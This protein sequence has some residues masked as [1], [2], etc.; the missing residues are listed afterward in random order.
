M[1]N[2]DQLMVYVKI[3]KENKIN[4]L[5]L[6]DGTVINMSPLAYYDDKTST[7]GAGQQEI[8][9]TTDKDFDNIDEDILFASAR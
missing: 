5:N 9:T 1:L 4:Q 8:P 7:F 2:G 6:P 3:C